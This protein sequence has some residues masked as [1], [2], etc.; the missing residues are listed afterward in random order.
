[1]TGVQ[2][3]ALPIYEQYVFDAFDVGA[4][5]YLL[6][7][8]DEQKFARVFARASVRIEKLKKYKRSLEMNRT[9]TLQLAGT[10]RPSR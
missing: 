9:L 10:S 5:Q 6:K 1:M 2:T 8:V 3:C 7:P 4:F